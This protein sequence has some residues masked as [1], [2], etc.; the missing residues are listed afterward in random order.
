MSIKLVG[1]AMRGQGT[2]HYI[3]HAS[4]EEFLD[5]YRT[6]PLRDTTPTNLEFTRAIFDSLIA[7]GISRDKA[8]IMIREAIRERVRYGLLGGNGIPN[9]PKGGWQH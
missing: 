9:V 8:L 7:A 3:A 2:P 5:L 1:D 4:L 6:G